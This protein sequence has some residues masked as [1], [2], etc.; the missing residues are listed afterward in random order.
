VISVKTLSTPLSKEQKHAH[1]EIAALLSI[2]PGLGHI[3]KGHYEAGFLWMFLGMPLAIWIG[4]LFGL[5][6]AGVGLLFPIL[7][8]VALGW[9]AYNEKDRRHHHL[10]ST[11]PDD[12]ESPD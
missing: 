6:T 9:D 2:V 8:W 5:A 12:D 3:Y 10:A 11:W 4:I 7:C 1:D